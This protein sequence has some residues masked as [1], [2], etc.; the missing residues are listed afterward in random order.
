[1]AM[2]I[3]NTAV[4]A[5]SAKN[6][7]ARCHQFPALHDCIAQLVARRYRS[8]IELIRIMSL[9]TLPGCL[10]QALLRPADGLETATNYRGRDVPCVGPVITQADL[11]LMAEAHAA[12]SIGR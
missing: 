7:H 9:K 5:V 10:A 6:F 1:M 4:G 8:Y 2:G 12:A 11:G 3:G